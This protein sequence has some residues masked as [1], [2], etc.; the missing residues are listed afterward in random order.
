MLKHS[1]Q[2]E[3]RKAAQLEFDDIESCDTWKIV[4]KWNISDHQKIISLK[5]IFIYK[6]DSNDYLTKYKARIMMRNDLQNADSQDVYADTLT[7]KIFKVL[8]TVMI[9]FHLETR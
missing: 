9:A 7:S 3:F 8:I 1:H 4:E 5:W 6:N 2:D